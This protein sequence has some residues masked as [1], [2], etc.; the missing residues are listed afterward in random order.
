MTE[1]ALENLKR[2]VEVND[3]NDRTYVEKVEDARILEDLNRTSQIAIFNSMD[4][5]RAADVLEE[6]EPGAQVSLI[7]NLSLEKAADLLEKMPA[8]E[9]ADILD[10]LTREKVEEILNEMED[11][12][13]LE[14]RTLLEYP[15]N[16][17]A[18]GRTECF[19]GIDRQVH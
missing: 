14:V 4:E 10:D 18:A 11:E 12:S 16:D 9:A 1:M 15:E 6:L 2:D 5:E 13:S 3:R 19:A 8:D 7:E 17:L